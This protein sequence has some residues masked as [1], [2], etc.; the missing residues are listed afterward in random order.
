MIRSNYENKVN[1]LV[2]EILI[3][4]L[5]FDIFRKN[6]R[7]QRK[8]KHK[9]GMNE[10]NIPS[11]FKVTGAYFVLQLMSV[12][13]LYTQNKLSYFFNCFIRYRQAPFWGLCQGGAFEVSGCLQLCCG[14]GCLTF[15]RFFSNKPLTEGSLCF[16]QTGFIPKWFKQLY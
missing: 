6:C 4:K 11:N 9:L 3:S 5:N 13:L 10:K 7:L 15:C 2:I 14:F 16:Q 8:Y 1:C 12:Q